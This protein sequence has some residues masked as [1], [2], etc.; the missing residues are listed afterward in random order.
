[1]NEMDYYS[2][3]G[4]KPQRPAVKQAGDGVLADNYSF[5]PERLIECQALTKNGHACKARPITNR[6]VCVGHARQLESNIN[7]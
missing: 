2:A 4:M 7:D 5:V 1:M 6:N 3:K